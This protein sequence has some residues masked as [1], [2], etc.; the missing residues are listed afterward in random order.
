VLAGAAT[1]FTRLGAEF[2]PQLDEGD[3]LIE[4]RRLTGVALSESV[5]T[6]LR[7]E[8]ALRGI[9][10]VEHVVSRTGAPEV[11]TD[12]MGVEQSDVYVTL[13]DRKAWRAGLTKE[14][15]GQEVAEVAETSVPEIAGAVSQPIEMRT[16]ELVAGVRSDVAL[17]IYGR[18]LQELERLGARAAEI[19]QRIPGAEDVRVEQTAGLKYLRIAPDRAKLVRYGLAVDDVNQ[20]VETMAVGHEVGAVLEGD[21]RFAIVVKTAHGFDGD[22]DAL[23]ALPLKSTTGQI[24][25]LGDVAELEFATG[26]AQVSR[27]ALSRRVTV[28]FNVRGRDLMSVVEAAR[29]RVKKELH[30]PPAYHVAWGGQFQHYEEA[31]G[32]LAVVVPLGLAMILLLLWMALRSMREALVIFLNV[33]FAI[34]GGVVALWVRAIP[35]SIS[36]GVGFIALFGVAVLNGLV[37]VTFAADLRRDGTAAGEAIQTAAIL[38]LRP[39]LM[40]ALVAALGFL[41]MALSTAPG[42][43][44]QRPLA[45]VVIGG[46]ITATVLTLLVLPCAYALVVGRAVPRRTDG[47]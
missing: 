34:I 9:P 46:L 33:P 44:V 45:T 31:K 24:V 8:K 35:F 36:A 29:R 21:R 37:L 17:L 11:A 6:D 5:A 42:S 27:E 16:N 22:I 32:R 3:L 20:I 25:P 41:P 39:V 18:D 13:K 2:I 1:L 40:T 19:V 7:L 30:P 38:R 14:M 23:R 12:P 43:E 47:H 10:E 26:P 15:L 28:E 4:A